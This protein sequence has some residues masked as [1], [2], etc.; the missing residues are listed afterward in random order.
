M[1]AI[2]V[3]EDKMDTKRVVKANRICLL[4]AIFT[5]A[6]ILTACGQTTASESEIEKDLFESEEFSYYRDDLQVKITDMEIAKRQTTE[7]NKTDTVWVDIEAESENITAT[8]H[9]MMTYE[10][11][12]EGW[13]LEEIVPTDESDWEFTPLNGVPDEKIWLYLPKGAEIESNTIDLDEGTQCVIYSYGEAHKYCD[14]T[15]RKELSFYFGGA[16]ASYGM[17]EWTWNGDNE[18]EMLES[19]K[20]D[21]TWQYVNQDDSGHKTE[22]T[23]V[24]DGFDADASSFDDQKIYD[25][26]GSCHVYYNF[27]SPFIADETDDGPLSVNH[28]AIAGQYSIHSSVSSG[29]LPIGSM[30]V[31]LTIEYDDVTSGGYEMTK[32]S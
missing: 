8:M 11:Y 24:I 26:D 20:I 25:I 23:F 6:L 16:Y 18:I 10:R 5:I 31:G 30:C 12:N 3:R 7:E 27:G 28:T 17:G 9:F 32:V 15:Y 14:I 22:I 21:G 4:L 29:L 2:K 13:L 19:W 1:C